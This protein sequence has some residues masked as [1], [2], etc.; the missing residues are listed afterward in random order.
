MDTNN[1]FSKKYIIS[2]LV[3]GLII[4]AIPLLVQLVQK[5][6]QLKS[7]AASADFRFVEQADGSVK[8]DSSK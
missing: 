2:Y 1:L 4:L 3:L 7:S 6:T 8:C 5:Q